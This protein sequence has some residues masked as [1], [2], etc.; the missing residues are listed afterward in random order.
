MPQS[1]TELGKRS[2]LLSHGEPLVEQ[3][4]VPELY[5]TKLGSPEENRCLLAAMLALSFQEWRRKPRGHPASGAPS[6]AGAP[7]E[8]AVPRNEDQKI[9]VSREVPVTPE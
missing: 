6:I 8:P 1:A 9:P 3:V 5:G 4:P 7:F 2:L